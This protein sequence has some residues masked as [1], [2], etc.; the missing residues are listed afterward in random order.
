MAGIAVVNDKLGRG[1]ELK[2]QFL[3]ED[4]GSI[5]DMMD[6]NQNGTIDRNEFWESFRITAQ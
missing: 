5:F 2:K 6:I 1:S 4:P 3:I